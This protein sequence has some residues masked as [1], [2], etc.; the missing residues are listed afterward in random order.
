MD[1]NT[2]YIYNQIISNNK[3]LYKKLWSI[4]KNEDRNNFINKIY[5]QIYKTKIHDKFITNWRVGMPNINLS[6]DSSQPINT[7]S[8]VEPLSI[9]IPLSLGLEV[10]PS[11]NP[12]IAPMISRSHCGFCHDMVKVDLF[13]QPAG[14][15]ERL[16]TAGG[17]PVT[18]SS[19]T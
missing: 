3:Y 9:R 5:Q 4:T 17:A 18:I 12:I 6:S 8:P 11:F 15:I 10:T 2:F 14:L 1:Y 19:M 13:V 7:L 16:A